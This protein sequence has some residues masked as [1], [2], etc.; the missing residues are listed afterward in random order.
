M[1]QNDIHNSVNKI[2]FKPI[3]LHVIFVKVSHKSILLHFF[4]A[5]K[6]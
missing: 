4:F 6:W 5:V 3:P 2:T 1:K